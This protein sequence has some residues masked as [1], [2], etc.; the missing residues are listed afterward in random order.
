VKY[1]SDERGVMPVLIAILVLVLVAAGG[2]A[3]YNVSKSHQKTAANVSSSSP[4]PSTSPK[5]SASPAATA[6]PVSTPNDTALILSALTTQ[7]VAGQGNHLG[8]GIT[9]D[10]QGNIAKASVIC[11][12]ATGGKSSYVTILQKNSGTWTIIYSGQQPPGSSIGAKYSLP[13]DWY[14]ANTP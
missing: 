10:I 14:D 9:P 12:G 8:S 1:L 2:L 5:A 13:A 3:V 4:S 6:M 7:C 11:V